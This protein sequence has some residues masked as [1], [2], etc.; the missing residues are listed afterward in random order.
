MTP[1]FEQQCGTASHEPPTHSL[2]RL[3]ILDDYLT[4]ADALAAR[5]SAEPGMRALAATTI[6]QARRALLK[7]HFDTLLLD[8]DL[9]GHARL[10]FAA[11]ALAAQPG[12]R[13][14][15]MAGATDARQVIDAVQIGVSGW[16]PKEEPI[17]HLLK[18]IRGILRDETWIPPQL[19][20]GVIAALKTARRDLTEHDMLLAK[21]TR[22]EREILGMLGMGMRPEAIASQ[23][24]L[25]RNTV[26][27]HIQR[28]MV[29]LNVHS[30]VQAAAVARRVAA[31]EQSWQ[32]PESPNG[33]HDAG[34]SVRSLG[35]Q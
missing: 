2:R 6:E 23:L 35:T 3:L 24:Y 17:E 18:V 31:Q 12:L 13:I 7:H 4:F 33:V 29:K 28:V 16:V 14:V 1:T 15:V 9:D 10:R 8:V 30:A 34:A 25:S 20:T 32:R 22:R 5:L 11:E 27:T 19:L 26:R 21:L